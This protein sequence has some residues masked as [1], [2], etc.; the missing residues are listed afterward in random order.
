[1]ILLNHIHKSFTSFGTRLEVLKDLS[2][3]FDPGEIV[4]VV[5]PNGC[6]KS[7]LLRMQIV[8]DYLV[9]FHN[10]IQCRKL[11][12]W[13]R[14]DYLDLWIVDIMRCIVHFAIKNIVSF[15]RTLLNSTTSV[16][17]NPTSSLLYLICSLTVFRL[18]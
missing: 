7:T 6:G 16:C 11:M 18:R 13:Y 8:V 2:F 12:T 1:M 3:Q 15:D 9:I 14:K 4:S 5:G 10:I 17:N